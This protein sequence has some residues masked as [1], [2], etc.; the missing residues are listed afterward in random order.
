MRLIFGG[1]KFLLIIVP[2]YWFEQKQLFKQILIYHRI[3]PLKDV[4]K[5]KLSEYISAPF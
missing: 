4:K 2:F 1:Q 5:N 3:Y